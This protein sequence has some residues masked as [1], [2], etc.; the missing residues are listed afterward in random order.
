LTAQA[1]YQI[2]KGYNRN[3]KKLLR[4]VF[5]VLDSLQTTLDKE[6][7]PRA[8]GVLNAYCTYWTVEAERCRLDGDGASEL[9]A[10]RE[11]LQIARELA[12][13]DPLS[14]VSA[15]YTVVRHLLVISAACQHHGH[16]E[17]A[18]KYLSEAES[19]SL[20][21][22]FPESAKRLLSL[23][24]QARKAGFFRFWDYMR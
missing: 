11:S 6:G 20:R 14:I 22:R 23:Q 21:R 8:A 1:A 17:E 19:I 2:L 18:A 5:D 15:E 10:W 9:Q 12:A 24:P 13:D 16:V 4:R 7:L 3:T